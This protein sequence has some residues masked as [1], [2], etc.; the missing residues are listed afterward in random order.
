MTPLPRLRVT[1]AVLAATL[2][3]GVVVPSADARVPRARPYHAGGRITLDTNLVSVSGVS[4]WAIDEYLKAATPLPRLGAAFV[5]AERK[6]GINARFLLAAAV[7]ESRWG[8]SYIARAKH[9]LFGY[10]AY[11]RDP[12]RS[13]SAYAT[14]AANIDDTARFIRDSYLTPGGRWWGGQPTLR[15]MQ[16]FWSSSHSWGVNV[17][18]I[19][20]SIHLDSVANRRIMFAAPIVSG[21]LHP[22]ERAS[23]DLTWVGGAMP[24]GV[25]FVATWEAIALDSDALTIAPSGVATSDAGAID[26]TTPSIDPA[27]PPPAAPGPNAA[28]AKRAT[29]FAARRVGT[30]T[31]RITLSVATPVS[32]GSYRLDLEMRDVGGRTLPAKERMSIPSV[33]VR[34][35]GDRAVSYDLEPR[36]DGDGVVVRITNT[37]RTTIPAVPHIPP[38]SRDLEAEVAHSIVTVTASSSDG[39]DPAPLAL[40]TS[41]LVADLL[42][43]ATV[44]LDVTGIEAVTGSST[45]WL[46]VNLIVLGDSTW[47]APYS[48]AGAW[49]SDVG[50]TGQSQRGDRTNRSQRPP[51]L[52]G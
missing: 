15:S 35:W 4:A 2:M 24:A 11:D 22:G 46:A 28:D 44:S 5:D 18:R 39:A 29:T 17:S 37:G 47:L 31:R 20:T 33:E 51:S 27:N 38:A 10:N 25:E 14:F 50:A 36:P 13:A 49:F 30:G 41:Q 26:A 12:L 6:Y 52:P 21:T 9:N 48:T 32:P 1:L 19:A 42:P 16:Q 34:V 7:H 3:V 45:N 40:I 43:G 8:R 23:V